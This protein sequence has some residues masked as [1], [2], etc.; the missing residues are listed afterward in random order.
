MSTQPSSQSIVP[1][2]QIGAI[3]VLLVSFVTGV[4]QPPVATAH[5]ASATVTE[6]ARVAARVQED[7]ILGVLR[8]S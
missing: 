8:G 2:S 7:W 4:E 5:E 1:P 6:S 3:N